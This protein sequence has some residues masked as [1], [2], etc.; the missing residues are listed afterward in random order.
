MSGRSRAETGGDDAAGSGSD[1]DGADDGA[2]EAAGGADEADHDHEHG[3]AGGK[4]KSRKGGKKSK[5][6]K[7]AGK[8]HATHGTAAA[9]ASAKPV[10]AVALLA[11]RLDE[12][13]RPTEHVKVCV[14]AL[15]ALSQACAL[16]SRNSSRATQQQQQPHGSRRSSRVSL[17]NSA[18]PASKK[19]ATPG[20]GSA[21]VVVAATSP[22]VVTGVASSA[23]TVVHNYDPVELWTV[24]VSWV[25][26][27]SHTNLYHVAF[28]QLLRAALRLGHEPTL[29]HMLQSGKL[30]STFVSHYIDSTPT[31]PPLADP[32]GDASLAL[33][34]FGLEQQQQLAS[35]VQS[36]TRDQ[37][38]IGASGARG[39]IMRALNAIRLAAQVRPAFFGVSG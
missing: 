36:R 15:D 30:I 22:S 20:G 39:A 29:R 18:R 16:P 34:G 6:K 3:K 25:L 5:S 28:F 13:D 38:R 19:L 9:T 27:Y 11:A 33:P 10:D 32:F 17:T 8:Q 23:A 31:P 2:G 7:G 24:L 4:K 1:D 26:Q 37:R 14:A 12:E 35:P 21:E